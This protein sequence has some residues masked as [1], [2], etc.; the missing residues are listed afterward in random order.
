[1]AK[2]QNRL[3]NSSLTRICI[4]LALIVIAVPT[5]ASETDEIFNQARKLYDQAIGYKSISRKQAEANQLFEEAKSLYGNLI[6]KHDFHNAYLYYNLGNCNYHLNRPGNAIYYYRI[7]SQLDPGFRDVSRNL[8][9]ARNQVGGYL[10]NQEDYSFFRVLF[11]WHYQ[12]SLKFRLWIGVIFFILIW[13]IAGIYLFFKKKQI[14]ILVI[15]SSVIAVIFLSS[16]FGQYISE[17]NQ[18]WGVVTKKDGSVAR[19]G[20]GIN[21]EA[22]FSEKLAEG[23]EFQVLKKEG[24]WYKIELNNKEICWVSETSIKTLHESLLFK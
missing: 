10:K 7:A 18:F 19:K 8:K 12:M 22:G 24:Q 4:V 2:L 9:E 6:H 20:P 5:F 1:M 13:I 15:V 14:L 16:F 17:E 3:I 11:F 21:Y 23:M